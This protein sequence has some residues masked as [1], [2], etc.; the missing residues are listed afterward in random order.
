[1]KQ[2]NW[3]EVRLNV[4]FFGFVVIMAGLFATV[5]VAYMIEEGNIAH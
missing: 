3:H 2:I 5:I 1:M 4:E